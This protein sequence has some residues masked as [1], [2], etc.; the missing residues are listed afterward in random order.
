MVPKLSIISLLERSKLHSTWTSTLNQSRWSTHQRR[1]LMKETRSKLADTDN[2]NWIFWI[3]Q[4]PKSLVIWNGLI[5]NMSV[6]KHVKTYIFVKS[7]IIP[8]YVLIQKKPKSVLVILVDHLSSKKKVN[9]DLLAWH[10]GLI[11]TA[12]IWLSIRFGKRST[13]RIYFMDERKCIWWR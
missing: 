12:E 6:L 5:W 13:A 9:G 8:L 7:L 2:I 3:A 11:L 10:H 4:S 1:G